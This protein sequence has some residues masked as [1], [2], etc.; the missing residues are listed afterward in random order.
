[1]MLRPLL[2]SLACA[3]FIGLPA[4]CANYQLGTAGKL[5]FTTLFVEPATTKILL[6]QA[7][8]IIGTQ[9]REAFL[10]DNRVTLVNSPEAADATLSMAITDYRRE[11]ATQRRD[12]TGLA[13]KFALTLGVRCTLTDRRAGKALFTDRE[14]TV[15]RDAYNDSGQTLPSGVGVS[16]QLQAEYQ[17]LPLLAEALAAKVA[18][19]VL[20]VW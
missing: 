5:A 17:A 12:D 11:V 20:D 3:I 8:A 19:A 10:R 16:G 1:M 6:P 13:R 9:V 7:Q 14:I 18:H 2:A 4:G 15:R